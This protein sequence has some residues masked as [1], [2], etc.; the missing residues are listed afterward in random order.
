MGRNPY[1]DDAVHLAQEAG[2]LLLRHLDGTL[3]V[4]AK[5]VSD[6]VTTADRASEELILGGLRKAFPDH[7]MLGEEVGHMPRASQ[8]C[9]I[10]DPLDGTI[11]YAAGVPIFSVSIALFRDGE[12]IVGVVYD[13]NRPE[14]FCAVRGEGAY[15]NDRPISVHEGEWPHAPL[16]AVSSSI[17]RSEHLPEGPHYVG[18]ISS[19]ARQYRNVGAASLNM[20]YMAAGRF[21]GYI[22]TYTKLWDFAASS[23]I[24]LEAG[25]LFTAPSG[26]PIF[27]IPSDSSAYA[28]ESVPVLATNREMHQKIVEM[29]MGHEKA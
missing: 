12:P 24:I 11:N 19:V 5:G 2:Q 8:Y 22:D 7:A 6:I 4:D 17:I 26:T 29:M 15:L 18:S 21:N 1:L 10:V 25:G 16:F 23:L 3:K 27:P 28:G 20:C 9:W 14:L 13:P